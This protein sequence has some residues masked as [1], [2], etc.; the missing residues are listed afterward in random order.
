VGAGPENTLTQ[1]ELIQE[2][3]ELMS[4]FGAILQKTK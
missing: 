4:I 1:E 3:R 2:A